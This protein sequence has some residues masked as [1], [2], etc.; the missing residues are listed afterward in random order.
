MVRVVDA[1]NASSV[2]AVVHDASRKNRWQYESASGTRP[3]QCGRSE[4]GPVLRGRRIAV[5]RHIGLVD[6]L[7][8]PFAIVRARSAAPALPARSHR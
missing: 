6:V 8:T 5:M 3:G 1:P 2:P 7:R 4:A